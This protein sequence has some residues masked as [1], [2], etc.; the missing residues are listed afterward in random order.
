MIQRI[1]NITFSRKIFLVV[2]CIAALGIIGC[3]GGEVNISGRY[4]RVDKRNEYYDVDFERKTFTHQLKLRQCSY[5]DSGSI[6]FLESS[7]DLVIDTENWPISDTTCNSLMK[8]SSTIF[9]LRE[10]V[11]D[12]G[13]FSFSYIMDGYNY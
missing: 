11:L 12:L 8:R 1:S 13:E 3:G 9:H 7:G 5:I 4:Y 6:T 10:G 2:L